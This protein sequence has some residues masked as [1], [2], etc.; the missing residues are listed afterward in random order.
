MLKG[1]WVALVTPFNE[2]GT[3]DYESLGNLIEF[4]IKNSINGI[5]LLGTTG[6]APALSEEEK[7]ELLKFGMKKIN[8][9]VPVMVG[10]GTNNID[11]SI[12]D[13]K[14][15]KEIGVN[16]ALVITPYYNKT[17][18]EGLY[19]YFKEVCSS[20]DI[21]IVL[22]NVPARTGVNLMAE[23]TIKLAKTFKNI[24]AIKEAS[25]NLTQIMDII[26]DAPADFS[27]LSGDD[28]LTF[29]TLAVGGSGVISV[30]AN[31]I[32]AQITKLIKLWEEGNFIETRKLH[33][34]FCELNSAMFMVSNPIPVKEALAQ[35][36]MIKRKYRLPMWKMSE[37][38]QNNLNKV[39]KKYNL[40]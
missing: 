32:P 1:S 24:V 13:T 15:A 23:T 30:T 14:F 37:D 35:M 6:E 40:V 27:L 36:G 31:I 20:V 34:T 2:D 22:Y 33:Y 17:T 9:R 39:L 19:Q 3:I 10:T 5:L 16:Y 29:P 8:G 11:K 7:K 28:D 4:Q 12:K 38:M 18:Q 26:K 25:G 21:P